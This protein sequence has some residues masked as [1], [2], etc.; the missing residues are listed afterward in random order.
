MGTTPDAGAETPPPPSMAASAE[1]PPPQSTT[2]GPVVEGSGRR[3]GRERPL[4]LWRFGWAGWT[5]AASGAVLLTLHGLGVPLFYHA[6]RVT[7]EAVGW[8]AMTRLMFGLYGGLDLLAPWYSPEGMTPGPHPLFTAGLG[9]GLVLGQARGR[10]AVFAGSVVLAAGMRGLPF[11]APAVFNWWSDATGWMLGRA[12]AVEAW[13]MLPMA[14][15]APVVCW[16]ARSWKPA[17]VLAAFAAAGF[18][19][20][21]VSGLGGVGATGPAMWWT[22]AGLR[23]LWVVLWWWCCVAWGVRERRVLVQAEG[24]CPGCG[25]DL[26]GLGRAACPECGMGAG[27]RE[28]WFS[29]PVRTR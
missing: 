9:V 15:M 4:P 18:A 24:H 25:Y 6:M 28:A 7:S 12:A 3:A 8:T 2:H 1:A 16:S 21:R 27:E 20:E 5:A 10:W 22:A 19:V 14:L 11:A 13:F 23:W 26:A 29:S 17:A